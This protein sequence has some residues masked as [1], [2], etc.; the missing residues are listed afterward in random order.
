MNR[1]QFTFAA[2]ALCAA[3]TLADDGRLVRDCTA[4][5]VQRWQIKEVGGRKLR[6]S[7]PNDNW[8][9]AGSWKS[10]PDLEMFRHAVVRYVAELGLTDYIRP[11]GKWS[12]PDEKVALLRPE[13]SR[14]QK[15]TYTMDD[16]FAHNKQN[17]KSFETL[18]TRPD[19]MLFC[20]F[21]DA[22][23]PWFLTKDDYGA[24]K[25]HFRRW[26]EAH[27][28]FIGFRVLGEFDGEIG[29]YRH[30]RGKTKHPEYQ[31]DIER[32]FK[33]TDDPRADADNWLKTAYR[34]ERMLHFGSNDF[35]PLFGINSAYAHRHAREGVNGVWFEAAMN[36]TSGP[37]PVTGAFLR[38]AARQ[39]QVP[40]GWYCAHYL[41]EAYSSKGEKNV[42]A[43]GTRLTG[44]IEW[45]SRVRPKAVTNKGAGRT[46]YNRQFNYG[47]FIGASLLEIE[48]WAYSFYEDRP[49]GSLGP[50]RW[51]EDFNSVFERD[52][53]LD[54]GVSY[55]PVAILKGID[56]NCLRHFYTCDNRDMFAM[57]AFFA[58][59]MPMERENVL[60][61]SDRK[62][63]DLGCLWNSK[64]GEIYDVLVA[65][66]KQPAGDFLAALS[67]Y[68]AAFL[69][70]WMNKKDLD[71]QSLVAYVRGGGTLFVTADKLIEGYF[72]SNLAGVEFDGRKVAAAAMFSDGHGGQIAF[73][74]PYSLLA[75]TRVY[76]AAPVI[77]DANGAVVAYAKDCGKGRVVTVTVPRFLPDSLLEPDPKKDVWTVYQTAITAGR[78]KF[79]LIDSLLSR[80][81]EE[82]MPCKVSGDVEWGLNRTASGWLFWCF[83]NKGVK[84]FSL[85]EER[86]DPAATAHVE[87]AFKPKFGGAR[88]SFDVPPGGIVYR[89]VAP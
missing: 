83:N 53:T 82:T 87:V 4:A 52:R 8:W 56:E 51:A 19:N 3:T 69:V 70:G 35:W 42:A 22:R 20:Q 72:P 77:K 23:P 84:K 12:T 37:W 45:R 10:C 38:G 46:F 88:L 7:F 86:L 17:L 2:A 74:E 55:T 81:Q 14:W 59:L 78:Q 13:K 34:Q 40:F 60:R 29:Q 75:A 54:R 15:P 33:I 31:A 85:E 73:G 49:D 68:R 36:A 61:I 89:T 9:L 63:G 43:D 48:N 11:I 28:N 64:F 76:G 25:E 30:N 16:F 62:N 21:H 67:P 41:G 1:C 71:V 66:A 5:P 44:E 47:Y 50:S 58:T 27:P 79:P 57:N 18:M 65:D 24:D 26:R 32:V 80:V 39:Y 6:A